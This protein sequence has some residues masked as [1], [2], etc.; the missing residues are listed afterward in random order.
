MTLFHFVGEATFTAG[1]FA[2]TERSVDIL[3]QGPMFISAPTNPGTVSGK[4]VGAF[5][6]R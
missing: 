4:I 3:L 1:N 5:S 6:R 2:K